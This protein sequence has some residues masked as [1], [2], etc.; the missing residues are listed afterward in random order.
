MRIDR[1]RKARAL[2]V[3]CA[4]GTQAAAACGVCIEDRV[5]A[6]YDQAVVTQ[7]ASRHQRVAFYAVEGELVATEE[8]RRAIRSA[9]DRAGIRGTARVSLESATAAVAFDPARTTQEAVAGAA[10]HA[11]ESRRLVLQALRVTDAAGILREPGT[12]PP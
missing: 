12:A 11:L 7:A 9:L 1:T 4:L 3:A 2:L 8:V 10:S 5:G 6:V